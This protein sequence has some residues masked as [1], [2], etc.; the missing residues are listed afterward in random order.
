MYAFGYIERKEDGEQM[1]KKLRLQRIQEVRVQEQGLVRQ[2]C[3][4]YREAIEEKKNEK[5]RAL[6]AHKLQV[7]EAAHDKLA[8]KWRKSLVDTGEAQRGAEAMASAAIEEVKTREEDTQ[9][10]RQFEEV[11]QKE[12]LRVVN[13]ATRASK[14]VLVRKREHRKAVEELQKSNREDAQK[15]HEARV[16]RR[17]AEEKALSASHTGSGPLVIKQPPAGQSASSVR[18]QQGA[19]V[20]VHAAVMKHGATSADIT[21]VK[22]DAKAESVVCFKRMFNMVISEM[23]NRAKAKARSRTAVKTSALQKNQD[24]LEHEFGILHTLDRSG[25]RGARIKNTAAVSPS[26]ESPAVAQAFENTFLAR[27]KA[28]MEALETVTNDSDSVIDTEAS[29]DYSED[30]TAKKGGVGF[31]AA[32]SADYSGASKAKLV[33]RYEPI[34]TAASV[35]S[36]KEPSPPKVSFRSATNRPVAPVATVPRSARSIIPSATVAPRKHNIMAAGGGAVDRL[37]YESIDIARTSAVS[38][39]SETQLSFSQ[40]AAAPEWSTPSFPAA[41]DDDSSVQFEVNSE[42]G[43]TDDF[44]IGSDS[45]LMSGFA[46]LHTESVDSLAMDSG[47]LERQY[48]GPSSVVD[49]GVDDVEI[50]RR[51]MAMETMFSTSMLSVNEGMGDL[52]VSFSSEEGDM[53]GLKSTYKGSRAN[54]SWL[55]QSTE[56]DEIDNDNSSFSDAVSSASTH[57]ARHDA[58]AALSDDST[59]AR[60]RALSS[61]ASIGSAE[62]RDDVEEDEDLGVHRMQRNAE[63][64]DDEEETYEDY[65]NNLS[66]LQ[67]EVVF[68]DK[69]ED[70]EEDGEEDKEEDE[71]EDEEEDAREQQIDKLGIDSA[72]ESVWQAM[73]DSDDESHPISSSSSS[74]SM[75]EIHNDDVHD[76]GE[77]LHFEDTE[78]DSGNVR[79]QRHEEEEEEQAQEEEEEEEQ[80]A[81][82]VRLEGATGIFSTMDSV[83]FESLFVEDEEEEDDEEDGEEDASSSE[84]DADSIEYY[85]AKKAPTTFAEAAQAAAEESYTSITRSSDSDASSSMGSPGFSLSEFISKYAAS[86]DAAAVQDANVVNPMSHRSPVAATS[87]VRSSSDMKREGDMST[88][89]K[90]QQQS[91]IVSSEALRSSYNASESVSSSYHSQSLRELLGIREGEDLISLNKYKRGSF[92]SEDEV[93]SESS[94]EMKQKASAF[95]SCDV[96]DDLSDEDDAG[97]D[98]V[99]EIDEMKA[100]L[101]KVMHMPALAKEAAAANA[102]VAALP[103]SSDSK[104]SEDASLSQYPL[105]SQFISASS[106]SSSTGDS[107]LSFHRLDTGFESMS[108]TSADEMFTNLD[109][110]LGRALASSTTSSTMEGLVEQYLQSMSSSSHHL[111]SRSIADYG[112]D[113]DYGS[114][115]GGNL[116][117]LKTAEGNPDLTLATNHDNDSAT[118]DDVISV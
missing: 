3:S 57:T 81:L 32:D 7:L 62:Y 24:D 70:E 98:L 83:S 18:A 109:V 51:A 80:E 15:A 37:S 97:A 47:A 92:D 20:A 116:S 115:S 72:H 29:V 91:K 27:H 16:S 94:T 53:Q 113:S 106:S 105:E 50:T 38:A 110:A 45:K 25:S 13:Q 65:Y 8:K 67:E 101:M 14:M 9:R 63:G 95:G 82:T 59:S 1:I 12:A 75:T 86:E 21:V 52:Q 93:G 60:S 77:D 64:K 114:L 118:E 104:I 39:G 76:E 41:Q 28:E 31:A 19:P 88:Y 100:R 44:S 111:I 102:A 112:S 85:T 23:N 96:D 84:S 89:E 108:K 22:N 43:T 107:S 35:K 26:E 78:L 103:R 48:L 42:Y 11:R 55:S 17:A 6:R 33:E 99:K 69:E 30:F 90:Y 79:L 54:T 34:P 66:A 4:I 56:Q 73:P 5:R 117:S 58:E 40:Q 68:L 61:T 10:K 46:D 49:V 74:S 87:A 71:E 2:R 36:A